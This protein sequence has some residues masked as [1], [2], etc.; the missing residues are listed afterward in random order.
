MS[1]CTSLTCRRKSSIN[2]RSLFSSSTIN[3]SFSV[4][5]TPSFC[6]SY[7]VTS[8]DINGEENDDYVIIIMINNWMKSISKGSKSVSFSKRGR[9]TMFTL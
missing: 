6:A 2:S 9:S 4:K 3:D 8:Y 5:L 1:F 7:T